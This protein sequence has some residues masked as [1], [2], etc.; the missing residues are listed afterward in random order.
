MGG[1]PPGRPSS[2]A[3]SREQARACDPPQC[4]APP[5]PPPPKA[6][7]LPRRAWGALCGPKARG[8]RTLGEPRADPSSASHQASPPPTPGALG[9]ARQDGEECAAG[10]SGLRV[11]R[12]RPQ[13]RHPPCQPRSTGDLCTCSG[14]PQLSPAQAGG[15]WTRPF[16]ARRAR[17]ACGNPR[18]RRAQPGRQRGSAQATGGGKG[19]ARSPGRLF[20]PTVCGGFPEGGGGAPWQKKPT[21]G[22]GGTGEPRPKSSIARESPRR[23]RSGEPALPQVSGCGFPPAAEERTAGSETRELFPTQAENELVLWGGGLAGAGLC[24]Q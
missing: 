1:A 9:G 11:W 8:Q 20:Q 18:G 13:S 7:P 22:L 23:R 14:G 24:I 2:F 19:G 10:Y 4:P 15:R 12:L 21:R 5:F 17:G 16:G 3:P 6:Q